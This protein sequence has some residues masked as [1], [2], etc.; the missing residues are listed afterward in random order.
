MAQSRFISLS[1]YCI[2]EYKFE[3]LG[4]LN[5]YN[6][7][8]I[9]VQNNI[10]GNNQIFNTDASYNSLKNI[11][12]LTVVPINGNKYVYLDSEKIP[13]Y[14]NFNPELSQS[15]ISG[16]NVVMDK[17]RFHFVSGFD[18]D[19]FKALILSIS[20]PQNNGI[21]NIFSN[22]LLAPET[23]AELIIFNPK[24]L[25]LSNSLYDRYIDIWV[26]SIKNINED[27]TLAPNQATTFAAAITPSP[28]GYSG[29]VY[30]NPV[31]LSLIECGIK[32]KVISNTQTSYDAYEATEV[33]TATVSQTNEFDGVGATIN[34][35]S[36][37]DYLEFYLTFNSAFPGEL[38]SI[39]NKRNPVDDWIIV[40]QLSVFEQ[41][42]SAF[43]NTSRLVFFQEDSYDEPNVFRPVLKFAH[44]AISMSVDYLVRLTNRRNGEQIIREA[45]FSLISPKKYGKKLTNIPLLDKPQSQRVY[46]KIIK[47]NFESTLLFIEPT[48]VGKQEVI[49]TSPAEMPEII[50][51]KEVVKTEFIPIFFNNNNISISNINSKINTSNS[52]DEVI[53]G[54]G[55]LRFILSPFD[56]VLKLK[57]FTESKLANSKNQLIPLDLNINS[58]KYRLVFETST[59]KV[60]IDNVNNAAQENLS[61]GQ[62]TFNIAKT[63]SESILKSKN[64]TVYLVSVSQDGRETLMYFGEWRKPSEQKEVDEAIAEAK[65]DAESKLNTNSIL[66]NIKDKL[67][68]INI[69]TLS[70]NAQ[71]VS[72]IKEKAIT[73]IVNRFGAKLSGSIIPTQSTTTQATQSSTSSQ[74]NNNDLLDPFGVPGTFN[75]EVRN[76]SQGRPYLW[77][78]IG[79]GRFGWV[80]IA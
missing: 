63:Q 71:E 9:L 58:S 80:P 38:I 68:K 72:P 42:G 3:P 62:I 21:T 70:S 12:D 37:G 52:S 8:F 31:T 49:T 59:G 66:E 30:N 39:L 55:K 50:T 47:N 10:T 34:E 53:F 29:L 41:V 16:Y 26:P 22:I 7:D 35:S 40:H 15:T 18:F 5:F 60:E 43:I 33:Y 13:N 56:N 36:S 46:N 27:F 69:S 4:S 28:T 32:T 2:A 57:V 54:P 25:F 23:I 74:S 44:E 24:P 75:G 11:Q 19:N 48:P 76:N 73:P 79:Q 78:P 61:T 65:R 64:R 67:N 1:S 6:D 51:I 77:G 20:H 45:S 17:V 14:L